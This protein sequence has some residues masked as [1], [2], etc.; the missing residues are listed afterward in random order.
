L[1]MSHHGSWDVAPQS[2]NDSPAIYPT[3][4]LGATR[5]RQQIATVLQSMG[6]ETDD[7]SIAFSIYEKQ[8]GDDCKYD[9]SLLTEILF[10]RES[11]THA[12]PTQP[13]QPSQPSHTPN[14]LSNLHPPTVAPPKMPPLP[15]PAAHADLEYKQPHPRPPQHTQPQPHILQPQ[16]PQ[17]PPPGPPPNHNPAML[18]NRARPPNPGSVDSLDALRKFAQSESDALSVVQ[19]LFADDA[20]SPLSMRRW[21]DLWHDVARRE[22]EWAAFQK[23]HGWDAQ[24][25]ATLQSAIAKKKQEL[26]QTASTYS[27]LKKNKAKTERMMAKCT[28]KMEALQKEIQEKQTEKKQYFSALLRTQNKLLFQANNVSETE[29]AIK[30]L[31]E[32]TNEMQSELKRIDATKRRID[33]LEA[34]LVGTR[35]SLEV[36]LKTRLEPEW[37]AWTHDE[38][39]LWMQTFLEKGAGVEM[40]GLAQ[41]RR[42]GLCGKELPQVNDFLLRSFGLND[43]ADRDLL[44][45]HIQRVISSTK[46]MGIGKGGKYGK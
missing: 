19:R 21:S 25:S 33:R 31:H 9:V 6:F 20:Q 46:V 32:E 43:K 4:V 30:A 5:N 44:I 13:T 36:H 39:V 22:S 15:P 27:I 14:S 3:N 1:S 37:R 18:A 24:C 12:P 8:H 2:A 26:L 38:V 34:D 23:A 16:R 11:Q 41:L 42:S 40:E 7:I 45:R 29:A 10:E 17:P 35:R 28:Q